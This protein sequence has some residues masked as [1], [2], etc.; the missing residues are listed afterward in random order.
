MN[1]VEI[2]I[3]IGI[4]IELVGMTRCITV[5]SHYAILS[6]YQWPVPY[7]CSRIHAPR[8]PLVHRYH[9]FNRHLLAPPPPSLH[10]IFSSLLAGTFDEIGEITDYEIVNS[11]QYAQFV[12][13][14]WDRKR[15][16]QTS[17]H[18]GKEDP[19]PKATRDECERSGRYL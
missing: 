11:G 14:A 8:V 4:G 15:K 13:L 18:D 9:S 6:R 2:R 1:L 12:L 3:R 10:S 5:Q 17:Q 7:L 16:V 19:P